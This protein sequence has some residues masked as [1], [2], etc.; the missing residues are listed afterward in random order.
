MKRFI[1][2]FAILG[3][4]TANAVVSV[5]WTTPSNSI[6]GPDGTTNAP[7]TWI[8]Q[9]IY[10]P[11]NAASALN[12]ADPFT[13]TGGEQVMVSRELNVNNVAGRIF[14]ASA[15]VSGSDAF[16][17]GFVYTRVF[18][19]N[20]NGGSP[21]TPTFYGDS[22]VITGALQIETSNPSTILSHWSAPTGTQ[23]IVNQ[24]I[25]AI[26]EPST[27]ALAGV[28]IAAALWRRRRKA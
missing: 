15:K 5:N 19:V 26:P 23:L 6:K 3:A 1:T 27:Y 12:P 22:A 13:P 25:V 14:S 7:S 21:S 24:Q 28:G 4:A 10:S 17:G 20:Y 18:N 8:A 11:D 9:L 16:A 2:L